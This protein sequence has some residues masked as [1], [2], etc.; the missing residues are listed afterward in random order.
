MMKRQLS[1]IERKVIEKQIE[2]LKADKEFNEWKFNEAT[3]FVTE[4]L[5][6]SF[7]RQAEEWKIKRREYADI[8]KDLDMN[9]Q[10]LCVQLRDGVEIKIKDMGIVGEIEGLPVKIDESVSFIKMPS[11]VINVLRKEG[12][13]KP[14][15][16]K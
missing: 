6:K 3:L 9:I 1:S 12:V 15:K 16:N 8:V 7:K 4:G 10:L 14:L 13:I 11:D 5:P 2:R